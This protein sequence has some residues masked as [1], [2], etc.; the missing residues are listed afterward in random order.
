MVSARSRSFDRAAPFYDRTRGLPA[1]AA[2]RVTQLLIGELSGR[3]RCLEV[4]VGTGRIA[5]PLHQAGIPMAGVDLSRPMISVLIDKAGGRAPF[6]LA[7]GDATRLPFAADQFGAAVASHVFHLIPEWHDALAE[8][9]RVVRPGGLLLSSSG[10]AGLDG[11]IDAVHREFRSRL[12]SGA[13]HIGA[14]HES[15]EVEAAAVGLGARERPLPTV[16]A[17]GTIAVG[18]VIDSLEAGEWSWAWGCTDG[19]R[20][21]VGT[22]TRDWARTRFGPLDEPVAIESEVRWQAFDLP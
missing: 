12:G 7:Q 9:I 20:R 1:A 15:R 10:G 17:T 8:V 13:G 6:P 4:G 2:A 5:W 22:Q 21:E 18:A 19:Q 3:G 14:A 11:V 16:H